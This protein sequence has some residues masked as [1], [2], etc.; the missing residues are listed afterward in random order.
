MTVS[1]T[2]SKTVVAYPTAFQLQVQKLSFSRYL[3]VSIPCSLNA[4]TFKALIQILNELTNT[5]L[6]CH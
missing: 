6:F 5:V 3:T 1:S 2:S 4:L